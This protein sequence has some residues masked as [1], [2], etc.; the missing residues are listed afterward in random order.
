MDLA[1]EPWVSGREHINGLAGMEPLGSERHGWADP[2]GRAVG[3]DRE[4]S[5]A[6]WTSEARPQ[7]ENGARGRRCDMDK[8]SENGARGERCDMDPAHQGERGEVRINWAVRVKLG[9]PSDLQLLQKTFDR[10]K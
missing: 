2:R 4:S 9:Q 5:S 6:T 3:D 8:R 7:P 1:A 10:M